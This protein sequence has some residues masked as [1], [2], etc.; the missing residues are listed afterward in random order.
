MHIS[1]MKCNRIKNPLGFAFVK[2]CLSWIIEAPEANKLAASK[3]EISADVHFSCILFDSGR[4]NDI[5]SIGY[6]P[7]ITLTP[8][9]RYF[10]RVTVWTDAGEAVSPTAWFETAKMDEPWNARWISP[11]WQDQRI[12]PLLCKQFSIKG[13]IESA[14]IYVCGLG[15]YELMI[16]GSRVGDEYLTPNCNAYDQWLQYQTYDVSEMLQ[17]GPN[18]L[19]ALLGNG[20]YKGRFGFG[21]EKIYGDQFAF[22]FEMRIEYTDGRSETIISDQS[23]QATPSMVIDSNLYDGE[24]QD[25]NRLQV[26]AWTGVKTIEIGYD[27]IQARRSLP[28]KIM[29]E[30]KPAQ[31]IKTPKGELVIDMGQNMVGWLRF[32]LN[33]PRNT[34][35]LLQYSEELQDGCFYRDNLRSAQA[36]F[37][38]I[39]DGQPAVVQPHFTYFGFRYVRVQGWPGEIDPDDFTGCVVYS[40]MEQTGTIKTSNPLVNRL[41]ANALWS[42]KGNFL[43]VP[44]DCPQRDEKLGWTGD[45]QVFSGTACFNMDADAFYHK[46]LHDLA[47]EQQA[48]DGMVPHIV[49][50][51]KMG[52][53]EA[54]GFMSGGS[55][56]W[57]DAATIIPWNL[58]LFYGDSSILEQKFDS[59]KAW[60][61]Y[62]HRQ[63]DGSH[64]WNTGF[65][66]G[67]WLA[68]DGPD[69][70]SPAGG[71]AAEFIASAFYVHSAE[72]VA[73]AAA[74]LGKEELASEYQKLAEQTRKAIQD[75][76]I[77][78]KGRLTIDTQ[79]AYVL[80]LFMDIIPEE[81]RGR[82]AS[83]LKN[84]LK[85]DNNHL[86]TGFVGTPYLCRTLS[87]N[88]CNDLA[89]RL[90]L[91]EDF[92]SWLYAVKL[93]A[94]TIW[95]RWNSL[96]PDGK[97]SEQG[98]NSLNHY[99]YGSI[100]EWMYRNMCGINPVESQPG[101]RKI[102]LAPQPNGLLKW[103]RATIQTAVGQ[104]E[105]SWQ[106]DK[107]GLV[108]EFAIPFNASADLVLPD[109]LLESVQINGQ[110]LNIFYADAKQD[111]SNVTAILYAG[112]Y[113]IHY[114]PTK[115]YLLS[116]SAD[117]T[118]IELMSFP[119][120]REVLA[121]HLPGLVAQ[122]TGGMMNLMGAAPLRE[123]AMN[124]MMDISIDTINLIDNE[125]MLLTV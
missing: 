115:S 58:Y 46:F 34:E 77:S 15:L 80:A 19:N 116:F 28:V 124:P 67:D 102:R 87:E 73:K 52:Q 51:L 108:F 65:H 44:T 91:N 54:S 86:K 99:A 35:I 121:I 93:G 57:G 36:A 18:D 89:Y 113:S 97:F 8:R 32:R 27:L 66:F 120:T 64:L 14:R 38:Y 90:L 40:D 29:T 111:G 119:Q 105:S 42:Q 6:V 101:F 63:D 103:A 48:R 2:P 3:V 107:S 100:I 74:V 53:G 125:L 30:L 75:E 95:E 94:T 72:I 112:K 106:I 117:N 4:K 43:D 78:P 114:Q 68:L 83:A 31:V 122:G 88:G 62:I 37:K 7:A 84:R 123:M 71:T 24:T 11:D 79:T 110:P 92:P 59:M 26:I 109:A 118:F 60:V 12:H 1:Q 22:L 61:D 56:V 13:E 81:F 9:I 21:G 16:N 41:F 96:L 45:A 23:W 104:F 70:L 98:M 55:S 39:S 5:D 82:T 33:A 76:F 69:P 25:V 49:P 10:W 47:L 50:A 17:P 85:I 20:W